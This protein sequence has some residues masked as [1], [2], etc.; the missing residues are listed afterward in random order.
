MKRWILVIFLLTLVI[1]ATG[2]LDQ[3]KGSSTS[4][5][6]SKDKEVEESSIQPQQDAPAQSNCTEMD[7]HP[8]A[9]SIEEKFDASYDEVMGWYC[10]GSAFSD[11]LLALETKKLTDVPVPDLLSRVKTQT[12]EE[13]WLDLGVTSQ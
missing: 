2:C 6:R 11:I 12:W 3:S 13:I 8:I 9:I 1:S 7:P 4:R 10:A 5:L